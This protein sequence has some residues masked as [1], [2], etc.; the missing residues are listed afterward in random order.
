MACFSHSLVDNEGI[1][2]TVSHGIHGLR[3]ID[4]PGDWSDRHSMIHRDNHR[5]SCLSVHDT[6]QTNPFPNHDPFL[7]SLETKK[8]V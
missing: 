6:F 2:S 7:L 5:L 3:Q 8:A 4:Q 1:G